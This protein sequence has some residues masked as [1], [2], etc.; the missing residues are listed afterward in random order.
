MPTLSRVDGL[1]IVI[2]P[3]DHR[4][5]HVHVIGPKGEAVFFLNCPE[6]PPELRECFGFKRVEVNRMQSYLTGV[7]ETLCGERSR[8]HGNY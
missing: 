6:G 4:P 7:L 8:I 2:Y 5:A 3:N 1:R